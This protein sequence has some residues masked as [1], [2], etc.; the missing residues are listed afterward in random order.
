MAGIGVLATL[1][2]CGSSNNGTP[3]SSGTP[4]P[5]ETQQGAVN[6]GILNI[7]LVQ[8]PT[9]FLAAG[10]TDSMTFSY[11]VDA[12]INEGLLWYKSVDETANAKTQADFW[13]PALATEVP[14]T[15]NGDVKTSG[16]KDTAAKMCVTWK[17]RSG[18]QWQDGS[19]FS[20]KD[21]C[22]TFRFWWLNYKD[23][24]PT[25][26]LSTTG[27]DQVTSC[28][29]SN[30]SQ[31]IVNFKSTFGPYLSFGTGV[32]GILPAKQLE[33]AFAANADL[34]KTA[35]TVDL[36][37]GSKNPNAF[38]GTD[39][40]DKLSVGTGP[41]VLSKYEPT[42]DIILVKNNNYWDKAHQ[43]HLDQVIFKIISGT[44]AQL[45]AAKAGTIDFGLDYRLKFLKDLISESAN[46]KLKVETIPESGSE[47]IDLNMC[48]NAKGLCGSGAK[49]SPYLADSSIRHAILM[50]LNRQQIIDTLAAGK[51]V[52]PQDSWIYLGSEFI[53]TSDDPLTKFDAAG[54]NSLLDQ[55]GYKLSPS[56]D[57]GKTRAFKDGTCINLDL[58]TTSGNAAR[59]D[60]EPLIAADLQAIGIHVN[61]PYKNVTAGKLFGAFAD[62]GVLYNHTFDMAMYTNTLS[63]P[64]EPDNW[65]AGYHADCGG[66]CTASV[67]IPS[68]ANKGQGQNTTGEN[69]ANIDKWFDQARSSIDL[70][71]R[72]ALYKQI[73]VQLSKDLPEIP[74][75][76]QVTVN[77]YSV[78]LQGLKRNDLVWTYNSYD[79]YC[80]AGNCQA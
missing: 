24:N 78:K 33:A 37:T 16:C 38:K 74:L 77:S 40:L 9:S 23:K 15:A 51:T 59:E 72:A 36:T 20:S 11:A 49:K 75:Y 57:G 44:P 17:L 1:A 64:A 31:A 48:D 76:Q 52:I 58:A 71:Q 19:T 54:A 18:V 39:T 80:T 67:Q 55:A 30:A 10:I 28:D 14:T 73:E 21:V 7:G 2:A 79:W 6:G 53:K 25:A 62:G 69:N 56:C 41:Y 26:V 50:G 43:P 35:Q 45:T 32:Y 13:R 61:A 65:Y 42:K 22:D 60:A 68:A 29:D 12:L 63:S 46:G 8:E 70:T 27:W 5:Q 4:T 47:K 66:T 34:E 3:G